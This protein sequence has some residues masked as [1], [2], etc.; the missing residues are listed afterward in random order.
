MGASLL[1]LL[2]YSDLFIQSNY[3]VCECTTSLP[4]VCVSLTEVPEKQTSFDSLL[5]MI[6]GAAAGGLL[7][8][9][10][11]V[12]ICVTC[13]HKRKNNKLARELDEKR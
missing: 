2:Y 4:V 11:S 12:V 3:I 9:M 10:L 5:M 13:H 1:H 8:M 6:V 7:I